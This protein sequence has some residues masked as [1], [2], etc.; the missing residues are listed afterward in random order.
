MW[1]S[2]PNTN[3]WILLPRP[4]IKTR[5]KNTG[6]PAAQ[7]TEIDRLFPP[8][9]KKRV[10]LPDRYAINPANGRRVPIWIADYVL[11]SYGT[12]IVMA[13][14]AHDARDFEFASKYGLCP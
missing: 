2:L 11:A 13:V 3:W 14:P 5:W 7:A 12:G 6:R 1:F 10:C 8:P 4:N 9:V